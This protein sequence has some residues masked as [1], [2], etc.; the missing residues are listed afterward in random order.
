MVPGLRPTAGCGAR[1][2]PRL[3]AGSVRGPRR[4][5]ASYLSAV[6]KTGGLAAAPSMLLAPLRPVVFKTD[7]PRHRNLCITAG[8]A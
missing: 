7:L 2:S 6:A 1:G 8:A 4:L 5:T 3:A